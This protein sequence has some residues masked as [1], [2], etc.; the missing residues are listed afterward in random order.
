MQLTK[1]VNRL[2]RMKLDLAKANEK[3]DRVAKYNENHGDGGR[4][5]SGE[6]GSHSATV[7]KSPKGVHPG[8]IVERASGYKYGDVQH[9]G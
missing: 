5:S 3:L 9:A 2:Q 7:P 1:E 4:F 6:G 8:T